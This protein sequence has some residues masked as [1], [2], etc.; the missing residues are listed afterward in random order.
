MSEDTITSWIT[1]Q[2]TELNTQIEVL[3][4]VK[5]KL[6]SLQLELTSQAASP[7]PEASAPSWHTVHPPTSKKPVIRRQPIT[8]RPPGTGGD[9]ARIGEA[10]AKETL[11]ALEAAGSDGLT[12]RELADLVH[13][14]KGT[15][16]SRLA[17]L[18]M[19]GQISHQ[20]PRYFIQHSEPQDNNSEVNHAS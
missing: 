5:L 8:R 19:A 2:I 4:Q 13:V 9:T 11:L 10:A 17:L 6:R 20:S 18:K 3:Q 14:P 12:S 1:R 15:A 7:V 16:S